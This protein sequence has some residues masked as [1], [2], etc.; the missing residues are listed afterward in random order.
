MLSLCMRYEVILKYT[1][2]TYTCR[3]LT[4]YSILRILIMNYPVFC[5]YGVQWRIVSGGWHT[6]SIH[7]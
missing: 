4:R 6:Y 1:T 2:H 3:V 7:S 5:V